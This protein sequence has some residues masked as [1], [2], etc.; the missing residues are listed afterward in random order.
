[1]NKSILRKQLLEKRKNFDSNYITTSNLLITNKVINFIKKNKFKQI[2]IYLSTKY[3]ADTKKIIN[4]C[5]ENNILVFVPKVLNDNNMNMVLLNNSS[6]TNLNKF[7][8][9]EP[10][11]NINAS[12]EQIDCIFT[13]LVGF[14]E[15]LNRIGMGKGFYDKF[16]SLNSYNYL[17]VGIC[18]DKQKT[19]QIII[20]D[21]DIKLDC[22]ITEK[23]LLFINKN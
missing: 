20:D 7:N 8:I 11:S 10:I 18:F 17:K 13:P 14:D 23:Q 6:L 9:Y 22:I 12:L 3:E 16:F 21:N 4:W 2:C 15:K 5:I 1:M 19:T